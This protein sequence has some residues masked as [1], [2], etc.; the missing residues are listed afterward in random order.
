MA[1]PFLTIVT[2]SY[3]QKQ[4]L[5]QAL[6]SIAAQKTNDVE[7]IVVDPGSTDGSRNLIKS[8]AD[9][10][11]HLILDPD[12]G[13]ADGLNHGFAKATGRFGYFLNADDFLLPD[14][15]ERLRNLTGPE[16]EKQILLCGAWLVDE[17]SK[18]LR[19]LFAK[20]VTTKS[21]GLGRELLVQQGFAF[22]MEFFRGVGG[23]NPENHTCWDRELL[24]AMLNHG[25]ACHISEAPLAA[26]RL[27]G[28]S[29]SGGVNGAKH[30]AKYAS[31]HLRL[32]ETYANQQ[33]DVDTG[34]SAVLRKIQRHAKSPKQSLTVLLDT[35]LPKLRDARFEKDCRL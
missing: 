27:H 1:A 31:D 26:F 15:V 8:Y 29:L 22:N 33:P 10:I 14:A 19:Q 5:Q 32:C 24:C 12:R 21:L 30:K 11:D 2:I 28:A 34:L 16:S 25:A 4:F 6:Q 35:L 9:I 13:P 20:P 18:P 7:Y 23:F 3:N 17:H